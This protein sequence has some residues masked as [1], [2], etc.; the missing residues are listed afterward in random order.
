MSTYKLN[1]T[2]T[3]T[4][5]SNITNTCIMIPLLSFII[6]S[7]VVNRKAGCFLDPLTREDRGCIVK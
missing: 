3:V 5:G 1:A 4:T 6:R 2:T 7:R